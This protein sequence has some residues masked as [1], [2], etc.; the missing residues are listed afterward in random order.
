MGADFLC[1]LFEYIRYILKLNI[2]KVL[3]LLKCIKFLG[4]FRWNFSCQISSKVAIWAQLVYNII[5]VVKSHW[6]EV[7][8]GELS[9]Q[10]GKH[11]GNRTCGCLKFCTHKKRKEDKAW[12][13]AR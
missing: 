1:V 12:R 6:F 7:K 11:C 10:C 2:L 8:S 3:F 5:K 13:A 4:K 9:T